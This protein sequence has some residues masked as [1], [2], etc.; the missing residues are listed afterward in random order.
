[1]SQRALVSEHD[2]E[3]KLSYGKYAL[4]FLTSVALTIGA[5]MLAMHGGYD[6]H[7]LVIL[8]AVL[9][10]TQFVVQMVLFL[11]VGE[12]RGPKWKFG[13]MIMMLTVV[14]VLV[15]GSIWIMNNLN[16]RMTPQQIQHYLQSQDSL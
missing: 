4:G 5:Y 3:P 15:A 2:E 12:E 14:I 16:Y 11:H 10:L 13:A 7:E 1:M 6:K 9:A 8:L